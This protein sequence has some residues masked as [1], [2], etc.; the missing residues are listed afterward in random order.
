MPFWHYFIPSYFNTEEKLD[1]QNPENFP[2]FATVISDGRGRC[3]AT[4]YTTSRLFTTC[5]CLIKDSEVVTFRFP[6]VLLDPESIKVEA[7]NEATRP[8][9]QTRIGK[10]VKVH[11]KCERTRRG[12]YYNYGVIVVEDP[13]T[14]T[15]GSIEVVDIL[16][17]KD[18]I[19]QAVMKPDDLTCIALDFGISEN[20]ETKEWDI[21]SLVNTEG[22]D[23]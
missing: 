12:V 1:Q 16:G 21:D 15:E 6:H 9:G 14:L 11:P 2:Y 17:Q 20:R 8:S 7:G 4:L 10:V 19:S 22:C 3:G 18:Q 23:A 13:F 5:Q